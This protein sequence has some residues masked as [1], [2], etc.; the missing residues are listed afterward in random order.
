[1]GCMEYGLCLSMN[2]FH[3]ATY[4]AIGCGVARLVPNVVAQI[5][6]FIALCDE[7]ERIPSI[8]LF[9]S[10]YDIKMGKCI[11]IFVVNVKKSSVFVHRTPAI[12]QMGISVW[13]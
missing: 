11:L 9:F 10:I 1:M 4:E 5:S 3:L 13:T 12:T 7:K 8:R 6:G 2:T